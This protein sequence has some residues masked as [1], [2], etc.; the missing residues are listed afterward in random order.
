MRVDVMDV[1][2]LEAIPFSSS[3]TN[4]LFMGI[5]LT[6][7]LRQTMVPINRSVGVA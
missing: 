5:V 3:P 1:H 6:S 4:I 7:F 2:L